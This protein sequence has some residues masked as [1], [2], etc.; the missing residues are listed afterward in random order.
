MISTVL[1]WIIFVLILTVFLKLGFGSGGI[2]PEGSTTARLQAG[3]CGAFTPT[4]GL[5]A[6]LTR[7]GMLG[8]FTLTAT[9]VTGF[10]ASLA[11]VLVWKV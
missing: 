5:F 6:N 9:I 7:L 10:L 11:T 4:G 1:W 2:V 8:L 3:R